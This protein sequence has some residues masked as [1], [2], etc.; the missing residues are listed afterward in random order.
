MG[1]HTHLVWCKIVNVRNGSSWPILAVIHT[2]CAYVLLKP[3][4]SETTRNI[5]TV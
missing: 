5:Y 4:P 2:D 3:Q 1:Y